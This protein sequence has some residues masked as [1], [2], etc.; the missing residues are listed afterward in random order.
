M[1]VNEILHWVKEMWRGR[2]RHQGQKFR[3]IPAIINYNNFRN[4]SPD[5]SARSAACSTVRSPPDRAQATLLG[6]LQDVHPLF[7]CSCHVL[8]HLSR[9]IDNPGSLILLLHTDT[10]LTGHSSPL[11]YLRK[12]LPDIHYLLTLLPAPFYFS[13]ERIS[14]MR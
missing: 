4:S 10:V 7:L 5:I 9:W 11:S 12:R 13:L 6:C 1:F 8:P 3:R 14:S 2:L